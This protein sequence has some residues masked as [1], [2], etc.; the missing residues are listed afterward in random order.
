MR[1]ILFLHSSSELYGSDRSLL[2]LI[3]N[4]DKEVYKI[5]VILPESGPLV[6]KLQSIENVDIYIKEIATLRRKHLSLKGIVRYLLDFISSLYFLVGIINKKKVDIVYTNTSVVFPGGV[7]AKLMRKKSIWH[8]REIIENQFERKVVSQI[9][10][11]FSNVIIANSKATGNAITNNKCK[12]KIVYNAIDINELEVTDN[13][14]KDQSLKNNLVVGMAGRINRWKGQKLF[15]DMAE[16]VLTENNTVDF[17]IAGDVY[18]D[19]TYILNDLKHY[20]KTKGL[21]ANITLLGQVEDMRTF[22]NKIDIFVLPSIQPE[23]F[24][25]VILEAMER[26]IPVVATNHGGPLEIIKNNVDGFLVDHKDS[27]QMSETVLKL[28]SDSSLRNRIGKE[29]RKKRNSVFTIKNYVENIS[30]II[31]KL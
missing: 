2:N 3:K 29:G 24:G 26:E 20:I 28:I 7:A 30:D 27:L 4:M 21:E 25:L 9:V 14:E 19:E 22:Y 16:R 8:I 6:E 15:V 1:N 18:K 13:K 11:L 17:L 12:L 10:N 5:G 31:N 23:P